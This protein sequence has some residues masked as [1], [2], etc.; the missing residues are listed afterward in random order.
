MTKSDNKSDYIQNPVLFL[1]CETE[2]DLWRR[3]WANNKGE[4]K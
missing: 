3:C 4:S 1:E 2:I